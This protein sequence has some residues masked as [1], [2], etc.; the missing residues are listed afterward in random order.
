MKERRVRGRRRERLR[1]G[2]EGKLNAKEVPGDNDVIRHC[3]GYRN[4]SQ[5]NIKEYDK[6]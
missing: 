3:V 6:I 1:S 5:R 2:G 4:L